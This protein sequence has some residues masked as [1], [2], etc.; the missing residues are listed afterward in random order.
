MEAHCVSAALYGFNERLIAKKSNSS[1]WDHLVQ[2]RRFFNIFLSRDGNE[3]SGGVM[4][5]IG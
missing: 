5:A 1:A 3:E 2:P 4:V